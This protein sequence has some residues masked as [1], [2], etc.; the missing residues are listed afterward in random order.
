M[1]LRPLAALAV[2][3]TVLPAQGEEA[4]VDFLPAKAAFAKAEKEGKR[5]LVY[6]NWP[7]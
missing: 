2:L 3:P 5:V 7:G 4:F 1:L 6:Q